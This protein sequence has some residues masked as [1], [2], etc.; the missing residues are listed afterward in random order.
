MHAKGEPS[1]VNAA[2]EGGGWDFASEAGKMNSEAVDILEDKI[3]LHSFLPGGRLRDLK[4]SYFIWYFSDMLQHAKDF[5][6]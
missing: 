3:P 1:G 2:L 5:R 6:S 4:Q